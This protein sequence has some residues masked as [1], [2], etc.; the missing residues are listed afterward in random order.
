MH[1]Y[2]EFKL[3]NFTDFAIDV[4]ALYLIAAPKTP[5]P[6]PLETC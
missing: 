6:A 2:E 4:S 3:V 1:V 5:D